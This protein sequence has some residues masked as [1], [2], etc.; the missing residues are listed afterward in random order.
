MIYEQ[1]YL[2][3]PELSR[4]TKL[5]NAELHSNLNALIADGSVRM[6]GDQYLI[7]G[8]GAKRARHVIAME[9][10]QDVVQTDYEE[11]AVGGTA[12]KGR[13]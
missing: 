2:T 1:Q 5:A 4:Y 8:D 6:E 3:L 7:T 13:V 9:N 10:G 12:T 11:P